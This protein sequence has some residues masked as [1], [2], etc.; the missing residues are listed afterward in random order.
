MTHFLFFGRPATRPSRGHSQSVDRAVCSELAEDTSPS[1]WWDAERGEPRLAALAP[2]TAA[3]TPS[4]AIAAGPGSSLSPGPTAIEFMVGRLASRI[5]RM[6][7]P[8]VRRQPAG[9][10]L[11]EEVRGMHASTEPVAIADHREQRQPG[12]KRHLRLLEERVVEGTSIAYDRI[13]A[14][15]PELV[16]LRACHQGIVQGLA[17]LGEAHKRLILSDVPIPTE[18]FVAQSEFAGV[19]AALMRL[20]AADIAEN[21]GHRA[22]I[23]TLRGDHDD[24]GG[25]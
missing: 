8:G 6:V 17:D 20:L 24:Q 12:A 9:Q 1:A 25:A 19:G 11:G 7:P 2:T 14:D 18:L 15:R 21:R 5:R 23:T 16:T 22:I 4:T 10:E 3:A 13:A